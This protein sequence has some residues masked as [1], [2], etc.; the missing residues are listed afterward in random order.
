MRTIA[1]LAAS[2]LGLAVVVAG[3]SL[4]IADA[5]HGFRV[6]P[7]I[8]VF[9]E[10]PEQMELARWAVARFENAGLKAPAVEIHFHSDASGCS[11]H[12][13]Y[14]K[15]GEVDVCTVLVNEMARRNLLHEIGHIW[16]DENVDEALR[17]RFL[18]LRGLRSWNAWRDPW[19]ERGCEHGAEIMAWVLGTRILTAQIA[20]N[21]PSQLG[22]GFE[23]LTGVETLIG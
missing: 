8:V 16:I 12:L 17:E 3:W 13:G 22:A 5:G 6:R 18:E 21:D 2:I 14:A 19:D 4:E 9:L 7:D 20:D 23:L 1:R 11:G 15:A 10:D